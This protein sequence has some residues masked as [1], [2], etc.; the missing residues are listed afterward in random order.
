MMLTVLPPRW[1]VWCRCGWQVQSLNSMDEADKAIRGHHRE[2]DRL[3]A[4][5]ST[6]PPSLKAERDWAREQSEN[7]DLEPSDRALWKQLAD[8]MTRR[9]NDTTDPSEGQGVLL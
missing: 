3:R 9:L 2:V 6:T 5:L 1:R 8:E 4:R 7:E